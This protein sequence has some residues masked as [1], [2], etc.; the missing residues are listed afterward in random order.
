MNLAE[1]VDFDVLVLLAAIMAINF[2]IVHQ[3][4]TKKLIDL[5]QVQI[6]K[7][8]RKGFWLVVVFYAKYI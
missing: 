3:K 4:E 1:A 2:I 7:N 8:P 6:N 5:L